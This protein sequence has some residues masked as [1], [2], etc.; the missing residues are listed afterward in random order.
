LDEQ[1]KGDMVEDLEVTKEDF[2]KNSDIVP[3]SDPHIF[4]ET[5]RYAQIQTLAAR[6]EKNP[7]LYNRLAVE[8]RILKQIKLPDINEV[9]PE[10]NEVREMN[11]A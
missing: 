2:A 5:Q 11:P 9:L 7:D 4:A 10:P 6:A 8:K 3:V 1:V